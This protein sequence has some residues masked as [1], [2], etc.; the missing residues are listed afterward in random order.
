[1]IDSLVNHS[2]TWLG[3]V[4]TGHWMVGIAWAKIV[5]ANDGEEG[6]MMTVSHMRD[7][8]CGDRID[9]VRW[10]ITACPFCGEKL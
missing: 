5:R 9:Y 8:E 1:M 2:C 4:N 6:W 7:P 3:A 10:R